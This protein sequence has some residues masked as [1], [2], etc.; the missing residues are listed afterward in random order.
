[1]NR[2]QSDIDGLLEKAAYLEER[3]LSSEAMQVLRRA[4]ELRTDPVV[5]TR[6]GAL[7]LHLGQWS[8]AEQALLSAIR[9]DPE[10]TY[11]YLYLGLVYRAACRL[12]DALGCF[13]QASRIELSAVTFTIL[14]VTQ[15][16]LDLTNEARESYRKALS[17]DPTHLEAYFNLAVSLRFDQK[18]EAIILL[19]KAI[20]IDPTYAAAHRELG[21]L[22]RRTDQFPEAEYHLRRATELDSSDGWAYIYLGNLMWTSGNVGSA[23]KAFKMSIEVWPDRSI[24]YWSFAHFRECQGQQEEAQR[25]YNKALAIDPGDAQANWRFGSYLKDIGD[26]EQ[27]RHYLRCAQEL[28]PDDN[29]A[30]VAL[31]A[32]E[33]SD[34]SSRLESDKSLKP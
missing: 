16:D 20:D 29:R 31:S 1:M 3:G 24:P 21:W 13:E 14:G 17:I 5:L 9:L 18:Q 4:L 25:L 26:Y 28:D 6:I 34:T 33:T 12:E 2:D 15:T 7:A 32:L 10:T 27:A 30:R 11:A 23:E 8:E 19:Q 22:F